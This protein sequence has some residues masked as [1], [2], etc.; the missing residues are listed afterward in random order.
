M[1]MSNIYFWE[2]YI[3]EV[4]IYKDLIKNYL[5][6]KE[7]VINYLKLPDSL[8][9]Y[10]KY[11]GFFDKQLYDYYWK[12]CPLSNFEGEVIAD[13]SN[14]LEKVYMRQIVKNAKKH[15]PTINSIISE[16]ENKSHLKNTFISKLIPGSIINPHHGMTDNFLRVHLGLICDPE[17]K[18]TVGEETKTWEEGK[19]LAFKDGGPYYHSVEHKGTSER[20][21]LSMDIKLSYLSQYVD[22]INI[23]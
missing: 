17:C 3:K 9:D 11:V 2:D 18:I 4:P 7:E 16:L 21:I 19:I 14:E 22:N 10:P 13:T 20:I 5:Q 15:C 6:I 23:C 1:A 12:A 8:F